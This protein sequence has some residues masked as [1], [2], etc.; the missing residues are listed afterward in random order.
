MTMG[1]HHASAMLNPYLLDDLSIN[2]DGAFKSRFWDAMK[3]LTA[4][5]EGHY[6]RVVTQLQAFKERRGA[7]ANMPL[8]MEAN[9][10]PHE[11]WYTFGPIGKANIG[12][13]MFLLSM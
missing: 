5:I 8:T 3:R 2:N 9:I 10:S 7:Y 6:G 1:L 12:P 13:S 11:W 4:D